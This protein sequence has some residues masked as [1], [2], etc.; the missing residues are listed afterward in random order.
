MRATWTTWL[1]AGALA[2][3]LQWNLSRGPAGGTAEGCSETGAAA[4]ACTIDAEAL[5]LDAAQARALEQLCRDDCARASELEAAARAARSSLRA[6]LAD[7]GLSPEV[8]RGRADAV[9]EAERRALHAMVDAV[10]EVRAV[11]DPEQVSLLLSTCCPTD[12]GSDGMQSCA[13]RSN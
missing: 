3:S 4:S 13:P 10:A 9:A 1:L 5:G 7:P 2:A 6:A 12:P 8:L 11:L